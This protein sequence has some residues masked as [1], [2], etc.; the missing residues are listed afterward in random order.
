MAD[1]NRTELTSQHY[2]DALLP[3]FFAGSSPEIGSVCSDSALLISGFGVRFSA[4]PSLQLSAIS[5][6]HLCCRLPERPFGYARAIHE[7]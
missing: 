5:A 4:G 6:R 1:D 3:D 7:A 2:R